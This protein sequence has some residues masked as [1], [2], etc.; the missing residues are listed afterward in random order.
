M[1]MHTVSCN[2]LSLGKRQIHIS[3]CIRVHE[4]AI[5]VV[6]SPT[7][8]TANTVTSSAQGASTAPHGQLITCPTLA[9]CTPTRVCSSNNRLSKCSPVMFGCINHFGGLGD[10]SIKLDSVN[11]GSG[12][13]GMGSIEYSKHP[14]LGCP[15]PA[16]HE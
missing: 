11:Q 13:R 5:S 9:Q 14:C 10:A 16:Q 2:R 15:S 3:L 12:C 8:V 6:L 4:L 1:Y 7:H